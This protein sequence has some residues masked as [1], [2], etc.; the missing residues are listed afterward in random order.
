MR[1]REPGPDKMNQGILERSE[2]VIISAVCQ[3]TADMQRLSLG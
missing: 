2:G 3:G 1:S